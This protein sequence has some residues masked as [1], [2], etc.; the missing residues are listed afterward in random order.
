MRTAIWKHSV[1]DRVVRLRGANLDGDEQA[2]RLVHGGPNKAVYAYGA[3]DYR[4]WANS[5]GITTSLG[6]FGENLTVQ[7]VDLRLAVVGDRWQVGTALLEVTQPRLPCF[8]LG[9]RLADARFPKRFL[10]VERLGAY[11]R[12]LEE[13]EVR[14][15]DEIRRLGSPTAGITL[16][17]MTQ[18]LIHA[19]TPH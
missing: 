19:K 9:V 11:L 6:L 14:A 3:E 12:V 17:A 10:S 2:D 8:K 4:Y 5:E 1:G 15:G 16:Q 13:G 7:H 18:S